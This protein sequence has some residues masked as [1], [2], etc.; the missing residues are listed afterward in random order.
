MDTFTVRRTVAAPAPAV[1]ALLVD[2]PSH[3]RWVPFTTVTTT[4]PSPAGV[5]ATFV[6][7]SGIGPVGFDDPMV[8]TQWQEPGEVTPGRC[9]IRKTGT[10]VL[11]DAGFTVTPLGA[12]R[13]EV[14]W[15][16]T[17]EIAGLRRLPLAGRVNDLVGR[18]AFARVLKAMASEAERRPAS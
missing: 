2:W 16:E 3:G 18:L 11:G 9:Q 17:I 1:W 7:R 12:G 4:S 6:G 15:S 10:V 8:V 13:C 5:G 14:V